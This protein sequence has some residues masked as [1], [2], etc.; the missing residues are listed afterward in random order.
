MAV[1]VGIELGP[2]AV[3][4]AVLERAG[5]RLRLLAAQETGCDTSDTEALTRALA[6]LKRRLPIRSPIVLGVPSTSAILTTVHPLIVSPQRAALAVQFELLQQLPFDLAD[7]AWHYQWLPAANGH[8]RSRIG[9]RPP[10]PGPRPFSSAV[11]A[12]MRRALLE[13]RL[14]CCRRAGLAVRAVAISSVAALNACEAS[15]PGGPGAAASREVTVLTL[16]D[17]QTAEWTTATPSLLQVVPVASGSPQ[18]LWQDV[19]ASWQGLRA[20]GMAAA[21]TVWFVGPADALSSAEQAL[22]GTAIRLVDVSP[23][24]GGAVRLGQPER[25]AAAIG[26][27]MQGAG[28]AGMPLNLLA[29]SQRQARAGSIRRLCHGVSAA[30]LAVALG[31][32]LSG[33]WEVRG[34]SVRALRALEQREREYQRVRPELRELI[35]QQEHLERRS[36]QL[37]ALIEEAPALTRA[38]AGIA[39]A[40]PDGCWLTSL[41]ASK[42]GMIQGQLDGRAQSF[43]DVTKFLERLKS[44]AGMTS[45]KPLS[46]DVVADAAIGK[47]AIAFSIQAQRPLHLDGVAK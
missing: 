17:A 9:P 20:Q 13:E 8:G 5:S 26:L 33:M 41:E 32:G 40:L 36:G 46:T 35:Q 1:A 7:A 28:V 27:A 47:E 22:G 23:L 31:F 4:G 45:V 15:R 38:L 18:A 43:Q 19:A 14:G 10:A 3:R 11:A 6:D 2:S 29:V 12:A 39:Q 42:T 34:R 16:L 44:V 37:A 25:A 21:A 30:C 24:T